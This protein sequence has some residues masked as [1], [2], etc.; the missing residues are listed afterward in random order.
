MGNF[1]SGDVFRGQYVRNQKHGSGIYQW[2]DGAQET[3][4]YEKGHKMGWHRWS[5]QDEKWDLLYEA[6]QMRAAKRIQDDGA[7][8]KDSVRNP[9][10]GRSEDNLEFARLPSQGD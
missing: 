10:S 7:V 5:R 3:G 1:K 8:R 4:D 9:G 6:G 2:P